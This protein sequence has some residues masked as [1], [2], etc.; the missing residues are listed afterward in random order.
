MQITVRDSGCGMPPE[1]MDRIFEPLFTTRQ[2]G[3]TGIGL[4]ITEGAMRLHGGSVQARNAPDGG[5]EVT[6]TVPAGAPSK[7]GADGAA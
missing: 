2:S 6:L 7:N 3:G 5:L 1:V 4:A